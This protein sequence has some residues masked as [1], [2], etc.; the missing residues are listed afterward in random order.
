[1]STR[2]SFPSSHKFVWPG[3]CESKGRLSRSDVIISQKYGVLDCMNKYSYM[4]FCVWQFY[5]LI[6]SIFTYKEKM[7][8]YYAQSHI[9]VFKIKW[10]SSHSIGKISCCQIR[11]LNSNLAY[12][13]NRLTSWPDSKNNHH[14]TNV[15]GSDTILILKKKRGKLHFTTLNYHPFF[16]LPPK[17]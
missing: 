16:T 12:I 13:K 15:I 9:N 17:L 6:M 8:I 14:E 5:L 4:C 2:R 10:F 3:A 1:M 11:D 7:I